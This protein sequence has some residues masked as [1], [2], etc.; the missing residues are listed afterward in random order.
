MPSEASYT[1]A[2]GIPTNTV[3]AVRPDERHMGT[4][5]HSRAAAVVG[6]ALY[7]PGGRD[8]DGTQLDRCERYDPVAL[9]A[10]RSAAGGRVVRGTNER[11][12]RVSSRSCLLSPYRAC[13]RAVVVHG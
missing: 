3:G 12:V 9:D 6:G 7:V 2:A 8:Y 13:V 11:A 1:D 10:G 5:R 4:A